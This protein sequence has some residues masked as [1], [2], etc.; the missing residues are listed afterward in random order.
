[1][2]RIFKGVLAVFTAL[3]IL[4]AGSL[5]V[6]ADEKS[7]DTKKYL[8]C[9]A[10]TGT[11]YSSIDGFELPKNAEAIVSSAKLPQSIGGRG[12]NLVGVGTDAVFRTTLSSGSESITVKYDLSSDISESGDKK[13]LAYDPSG[14]VLLGIYAGTGSSSDTG[15]V[16]ARF[17]LIAEDGTKYST[18][19]GIF[20]HET[21][22]VYLDASEFSSTAFDELRVTLTP[23]NSEKS[24]TVLTSLPS[25]LPSFKLDVLR[26]SGIVSAV[27]SIGS[28]TLDSTAFSIVGTANLYINFEN[29][30]EAQ[31]TVFVSLECSDGEAG[32]SAITGGSGTE[33][34]H[35]L[36][37]SEIPLP[38][39]AASSENGTVGLS[40]KI[41][42]E[43]HITLDSVTCTA[44]DATSEEHGSF[45]TLTITDT[46]LV[47]TGRIDSESVALYS[48]KY[49]GLFTESVTSPGE[50]ILLK[51]IKMTSRFSFSVSVEDYP[52]AHADNVFY[53]AVITDDGTKQ[54]T[55]QRFASA[56]TPVLPTG[57]IYALHR[58]NPISVFE[59]GVQYVLVDVDLSRL[60]TDPSASGTTVSR[61]E[62]IYGISAE[63][64]SELDS[65]MNFYGSIGVSVYVRLTCTSSVEGN[66]G[67][68][69]ASGTT[70]EVIAR[71]DSP[72]QLNSYPAAASFLSQ[73][74]PGISS[75]VISSGAN[76]SRLTGIGNDEA[77]EGASCVAMI[78][79]LVYGAASRHIDGITVTIQLAD[80]SDELYASPELFCAIFGDKL[81]SLGDIPWAIMYTAN[82]DE[83]SARYES[84]KS[85]A[86]LNSSST[87]LYI[88]AIYPMRTADA[89]SVES[90]EA[91]CDACNGT[92]VKAAFLSASENIA[93]PRECCNSL[94]TAGDAAGEL[95]FAAEAENAEILNSLSATGH[96]VLWDF[97]SS[98]STEGWRESYG[99]S[100]V[101]S[102]AGATS[103]AP[104]KLHCSTDPSSQASIFLV[105]VEKGLDLSRAPIAEF[106]FEL[107][108]QDD[109][110]LVFIF[111]NDSRRAEFSMK[112]RDYYTEDGRLRVLCDLSEFSS[113]GKV[114]Y[115]GIIVYSADRVDISLSQVSAYSEELDSDGIVDLL[116][117]RESTDM[118]PPP[119]S[120]YV[121]AVG[122]SA[123]VITVAT[124]RLAVY[125]VRRDTDERKSGKVGARRRR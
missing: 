4:F 115:I 27:S 59:S 75:F 88:A 42:E 2:S 8:R 73:R 121:I 24:I 123:L 78:S 51:R 83:P 90:Y 122:I 6:K 28:M 125:F 37:A 76:S 114:S 74:Y 64:L 40:F 98:Y 70:D 3:L 89:T 39:R 41:S 23:D 112:N 60:I 108:A 86:H 19:I 99:M 95:F 116:N 104:R 102:A 72:K 119:I 113:L 20:C 36:S 106:L 120:K 29:V 105:P 91:F 50:S 63:Y 10:L 77:F 13:T 71:T 80:E 55:P 43:K 30:T 101:V 49:I 109:A 25:E 5:L 57:N 26:D 100:C 87:P 96:G 117:E 69:K 32:V 16:E 48:G 79:R 118:S 81:S 34:S 103:Q 31:R 46:K 21:Y 15:R 14:T 62:Y 18:S 12:E 7:D 1:M 124:V 85:S 47:A 110:Q 35:A 111:G 82:S 53:V 22:I 68:E 11:T 9:A 65:D 67:T 61:G 107:D 84:L 17:D 52:H 56:G 54:L 45:T 58:A 38:I 97:S 33:V 93:L 66:T 94:K 44:G 92:S